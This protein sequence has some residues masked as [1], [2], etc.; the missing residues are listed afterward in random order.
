MPGALGTTCGA[1]GTTNSWVYTFDFTE[2]NVAA[3]TGPAASTDPNDPNDVLWYTYSVYL[4]YD[5]AI[6]STLGTGNL[7]QM[8]QVIYQY[9]LIIESLVKNRNFGQKSKFWSK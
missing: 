1:V 9:R 2:C 7:R 3:A 6:D 5:N 8:D 4:N